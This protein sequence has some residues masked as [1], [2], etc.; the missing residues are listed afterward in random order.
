MTLVLVL[1]LLVVLLLVVVLVVVLLRLLLLLLVLLVV[2]TLSLTSPLFRSG[3]NEHS[4][5]LALALVRAGADVNAPSLSGYTPLYY[6]VALREEGLLRTLLRHGA[7][8]GPAS[9]S[10]R[11][12]V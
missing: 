4:V 7:T 11:R 6:A 2:L 1:V 3:R 12:Q 5:A 9:A 8:V 10:Q